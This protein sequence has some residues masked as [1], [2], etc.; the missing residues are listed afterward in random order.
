MSACKN[1]M[2]VLTEQE[3]YCSACGAKVIRNRLTIKNL[4]AD[5]SEQFLNYDNKLLKTFIQLFRKPEDVIGSYI[6][7]T[8][9]KYVNVVSFYAIALTLAGLQLFVV[10]KFFPESLD[11]TVFFP[12]NAAQPT[13]DME[14]MYDYQSIVALVN[15]PLYALMARITFWGLKKFNYTEHLVIMTYIIGQFTIVSFFAVT[16]GVVLGGNFYVLN[17]FGIAFLAIFTTYCYRRLY[18]LSIKQCFKRIG[19]FLLVIMVFMF[20]V[21]LIQLVVMYFNGDLQQMMQDAIEAQKQKN[22]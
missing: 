4:T 10:R 15:L 19:V 1:C 20:L 5:F 16:L 17:N 9:K 6:D 14:W 7:G 2:A 3:D 21:S 18:P 8:R 12:E 11:I 13:M 22:N